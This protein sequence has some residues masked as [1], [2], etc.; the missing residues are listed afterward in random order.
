V[1]IHTFVF[2]RKNDF[3]LCY[4]CDDFDFTLSDFNQSKSKFRGIDQG[5]VKSPGLTNADSGVG[6]RVQKRQ[7]QMGN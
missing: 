2:V 6:Y 3:L 4:L 7:I 5:A 1:W